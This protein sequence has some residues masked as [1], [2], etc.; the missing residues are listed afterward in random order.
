[1]AEGVPVL[2]LFTA[3]TQLP[4]PG[5][6]GASITCTRSQAPRWPA[7]NAWRPSA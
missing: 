7:L 1:M 2:V 4:C 6:S 5:V 3:D